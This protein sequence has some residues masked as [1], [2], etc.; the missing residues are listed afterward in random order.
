MACA[1]TTSSWTDFHTEGFLAACVKF[2]HAVHVDTTATVNFQPHPSAP[3]GTALA[4]PAGRTMVAT[5]T[6]LI[7]LTLA[8]G[9]AGSL[10]C[11]LWCSSPAAEDHQRAVGCHD[12]SRTWP[13]GQ[14]VV[15][16]TG[17]HDAAALTP[18]LTEARQ[19]ESDSVA[20]AASPCVDSSAI[21]PDNVGATAGCYVFNVQS[22][23]PPTSRVV[24][25]R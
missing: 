7:V 22:P 17:C 9:P 23:R 6:L 21:G 25:R 15:S 11:E 5:T 8:G 14:Q 13:T 2:P 18:F 4:L 20:A 10:A 19:T 1:S 16:T 3:G 24:L 12:A